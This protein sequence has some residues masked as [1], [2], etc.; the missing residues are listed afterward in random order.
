MAEDTIDAVG[1]EL[2][3]SLDATTVLAF[4]C[5][6]AITGL[7]FTAAERSSSCLN[8]TI[9][10][11]KPGKRTLSNFQV[12]FRLITGSEAHQHLLSLTKEGEP[13]IELPYAIALSDGTADPTITGGEFVPPGVAPNYTRT[14]A[15]GTMYIGSV[16]IDAT[17]GE[18]VMGTFTAMPQ[19]QEW[20][21]KPAA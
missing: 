11:S 17:D 14:M 19:S 7:G 4:D 13:N 9:A 8:E 5:P 2:F 10:K 18:D 1:T 12:P 20:F 3:I 21:P 6:T 16:S 15:I